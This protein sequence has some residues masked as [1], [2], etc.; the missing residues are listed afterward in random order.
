MTGMDAWFGLLF[1]CVFVWFVV[2][3]PHI[4]FV[5]LAETHNTDPP[6]FTHA[7]HPTDA[8]LT[9]TKAETTATTAAN[10]NDNQ[11]QPTTNDNAYWDVNPVVFDS[12]VLSGDVFRMGWWYSKM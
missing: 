9:S 7:H 11:L 12:V 5:S 3:T 10:N 8:T 4:Q 2:C 6:T 1:V